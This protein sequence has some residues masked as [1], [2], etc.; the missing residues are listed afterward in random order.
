MLATTTTTIELPLSYSSSSLLSPASAIHAK[1]TIMN[2]TTFASSNA[3]HGRCK[4]KSGR[5]MNERT[6]K[7]NG[8]PHTLCEEHRL[9]HNKNQRKS[10]TKRRRLRRALRNEPRMASPMRSA[11]M[12]DSDDALS[13]I[14]CSSPDDDDESVWWSQ[15]PPMAPITW[16]SPP[17]PW[18][19]E[20]LH[21]LSVLLDLPLDHHR[22][23]AV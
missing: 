17:E 20:E 23:N 15:L 10:D 5:C 19:P 4:Y 14:L 11:S 7:E 21:I 1:K 6:I 16:T 3:S 9:L 22:F 13:S 12:D 18:T 2:T 8:E